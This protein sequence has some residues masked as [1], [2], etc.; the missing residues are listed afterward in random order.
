MR[1]NDEERK[2]RPTRPHIGV[3]L[4]E[5]VQV[6]MRLKQRLRRFGYVDPVQMRQET[7]GEDIEVTN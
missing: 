2:L 3:R 4:P 7:R 6:D 5:D 1:G